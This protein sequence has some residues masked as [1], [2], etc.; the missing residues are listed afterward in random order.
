LVP[1]DVGH[2]KSIREGFDRIAVGRAPQALLEG[3]NRAKADTS[4]IS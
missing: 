1:S 3:S 4:A 2:T